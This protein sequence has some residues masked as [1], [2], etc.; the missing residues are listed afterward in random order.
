MYKKTPASIKLT[1]AIRAPS[2]EARSRVCFQI[3]CPCWDFV[4]RRKADGVKVID[5]RE[6]CQQN[7]WPVSQFYAKPTNRRA[8]AYHPPD[9]RKLIVSVRVT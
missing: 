3:G 4:C 9:D 6:A 2:T 7:F 5:S 1:G 8:I